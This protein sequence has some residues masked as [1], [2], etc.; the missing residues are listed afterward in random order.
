VKKFV[1]WPYT[2]GFVVI[3]IFTVLPLIVS[4]VAGAI[5]QSHG[6]QMNEGG[7]FGCALPAGMSLWLGAAFS[8]ALLIFFTVPLGIVLAVILGIVRAIHH[9]VWQRREKER[10]Q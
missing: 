10:I 3:G 7:V 9:N 1:T 4:M 6:C 2:V 5:G 8:A